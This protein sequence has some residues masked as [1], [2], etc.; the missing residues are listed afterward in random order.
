VGSLEIRPRKQTDIALCVDI[1]RRV[2][3]R[4]RY[5]THW[6]KDPL[7]F[8]APTYELVAWVAELDGEVLGHVA[9]HDAAQD[10]ACET[11][12]SAAHLAAADLA[13]VG[14]LFV[15]PEHRGRNVG[16]Q[17]LSTAT[18]AAHR[19]GQRPFL[20]VAQS[21]D[22]AIAMYER[23]RWKN[24]GPL[25]IHFRDGNVLDTFVYLGPEAPAVDG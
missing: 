13:A 25:S 20:N 5:P 14:R 1:L 8:V 23:S 10:P 12:Q 18:E 21:L 7:R 19:Q 9:L 3:H 2:H 4:D 11:A 15:A 24:L 17:L 6:P 22:A 16:P